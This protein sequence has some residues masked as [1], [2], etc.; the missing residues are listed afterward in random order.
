MNIEHL[1]KRIIEFYDVGIDIDIEIMNQLIE[2][3]DVKKVKER[4][5]PIFTYTDYVRIDNGDWCPGESL[6]TVEK[7]IENGIKRAE[8][9]LNTGMLE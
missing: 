1:E 7:A 5:T 9:Y 8:R 3:G 4:D 2:I 6:N